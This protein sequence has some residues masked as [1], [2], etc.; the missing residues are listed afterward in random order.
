MN[1]RIP[2]ILALVLA[3]GIFF[4]Y[5]NPAWTGSIAT[6]KAAIANDDQA[7]A[8]AQQFAAQ[9][10]QLA[11]ARDAIDPAN[12]KALDTFLPS[13]VDNVGLILDLNALASR[14]GLSIANVDVVTDA[15]GTTNAQ[16]AGALTANAV[17]PVA[18]VDLAISATGTFA[19]L[20][21]FLT[22]VEKSARLLDVHDLAV[23]GSDTGVYTYRM[24]L[25]L[26]W[27]R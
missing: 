22:G 7:L 16:S 5:V 25:S 8:T 17:N 4:L 10:N 23:K 15:S 20:Q 12:Q 1:S 13:S 3:I 27:L 24:T 19:A 2:P 9:Q 6:A 11:A 14:S 18:S 21:A 26:Y